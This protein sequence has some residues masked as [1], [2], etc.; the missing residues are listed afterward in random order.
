VEILILPWIALSAALGRC[1]V[2]RALL[3]IVLALALT[4]SPRALAQQVE[5]EI[6]VPLDEA[7]GV[8]ELD[9]RLR[10]ELGLF[11]EVAGFGT[12]RLFRSEAGVYVL[13]IT[14][15]AQ[16]A[17]ARERRRLSDAEL[18]SLRADLQSRFAALGR[19]R[20]VDRSGRAGFIVGQTAVGLGYHGWVVPTVFDIDSSRGAV[21]AYLLTAG[22][23]FL[24]PWFITAGRPVSDAQR[25]AAFWGATRGIAYGLVIGS[26]VAPEE[27]EV[28]IE[29]DDTDVRVRLAS[30]SLVSVLGTVAGYNAA[31]LA[32]HAPGTVALWS[33]VGDFG[34][35]TAFGASY[36]LGL[37]NDTD[38]DCPDCD[39]DLTRKGGNAATLGLGLASLLAAERWGDAEDYTI[40]DAR[41]LRSFGL[42]GAHALLAPAVEAFEDSEWQGQ[43]VVASALVGTWAGLYLGNRALRRTSLSDGEGL[44]VLAGHVAGGLV[45]LGVTYLLDSGDSASA[46]V[47]LATSAG[48]AALG[49]LLTFNA[50]RGGDPVTG[51]AGSRGVDFTFDPAGLLLPVLGYVSQDKATRARSAPFLTLRF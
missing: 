6:Q 29:D 44:L 30:G 4:P 8:V 25:D 12:A 21:A 33:A 17:L 43:R 5:R 49:S 51:H 11:P 22:S 32:D 37:F 27:P 38:L 45:A 14:Y 39:I 18:A 41:A 24:I 47:Y 15:I 23:G 48:G 3:T 50:V 10:D 36:A 34:L 1:S 2:L 16:G 7:R 40:G 46:T 31:R 28:P 26:L 20:V 19:E 35:A 9:A 42:L 13:E